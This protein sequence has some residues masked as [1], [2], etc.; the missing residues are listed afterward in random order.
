M[1]SGFYT[2]LLL[3]ISGWI[4]FFFLSGAYASLYLQSKLTE[5]FR[6]MVVC[7]IAAITLLFF[8]V[9]KNPH[10]N[11]KFYYLEFLSLLIPNLFL[12]SVSR[13]I[14]LTIAK[15]QVRQG[16]VY[17][18]TLLIGN[19]KQADD[20]Y[21]SFSSSKEHSGY[22]I[23]GFV[24]TNGGAPTSFD[25]DILISADFSELETL[26]SILHIEEVIITVDKQNRD[27]IN[28]ILQKLSDKEVNIKITPD[29]VDIITGALHTNNVFGVPLIDIH[30]GILPHWQQNI[31]RLIDLLIAIPTFIL[32][33][34]LMLYIIIRVKGS[35]PGSI[36]FC[37]ERIGY[38]GKPFMMY[39]FRS[40][41]SDAEKDGPSLSSSNDQRITRWGRIMRKWRMDELP[42]LWNVIK[43]EMSLV[44]PRAERKFY[45]DKIVPLHPEYKYLFKV[46]PGI[47]SW[48]MV[49]FGYASTVDEMIKRMPY[50]LLY[51]E[52]V[53]LALDV[54][55]LIYTL[56]IIFSG[57]GK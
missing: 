40:M 29:T 53:S 22:R 35:S 32:L 37:Q 55:I 8:F 36:I 17:F 9:L 44:G 12:F 19:A 11:N 23:T 39:K 43:G 6:T 14:W 10:E 15:Q 4:S 16:R 28:M 46:K 21:R 33:S 47:T 7:L 20:F 25:T 52:N 34:P 27:L 1:P 5:L 38:K 57:K 24:N 56:Q 30:S 18:N 2:G 26:I 42:Q 31:K 50:D 48:G 13:M 49:K 41:Y 3:Y 54:K 51:V 45:I